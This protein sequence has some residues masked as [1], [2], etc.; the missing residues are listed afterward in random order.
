MLSLNAESSKLGV[1]NHGWHFDDQCY[2]NGT[3]CSV[4]QNNPLLPESN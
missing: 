3:T 4:G 1:T 2:L